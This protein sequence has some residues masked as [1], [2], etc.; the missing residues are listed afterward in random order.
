MR[1]GRLGVAHCIHG[2]RPRQLIAVHACLGT[3]TR[4]LR[5]TCGGLGARTFWLWF[6]LDAHVIADMQYVVYVNCWL[7]RCT[8]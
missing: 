8:V 2:R 3:W 1:Y 6:Q 7:K 5:T 4:L